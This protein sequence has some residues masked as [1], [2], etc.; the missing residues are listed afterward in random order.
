MADKLKNISMSPELR[1]KS[2]GAALERLRL[3]RNITQASLARDAGISERTL[4]R[5]ES[6]NGGT[7]DSLFRVLTT[8]RLDDNIDLLVPDPH[9]RPIERIRTKGS[10]RQRSS[11]SKSVKGGGKW[12]WG[13]KEN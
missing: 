11:S 7:L 13:K 5:L 10:E 8:L 3:S 4:R 1:E 12:D 9:I 2:V 6:G